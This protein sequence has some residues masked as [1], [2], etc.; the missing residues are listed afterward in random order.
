MPPSQTGRLASLVDR[1]RLTWRFG[2][3]VGRI[4]V[5]SFGGELG[6]RRVNHCE[7]RP[8]TDPLSASGDL[9]CRQASQRRD[10]SVSER[11][12]LGRH[13]QLIADLQPGSSEPLL[14]HDQAAELRDEPRRDTGCL[15]E[16][17]RVEPATKEEEEPPQAGVRCSKEA[18][19]RSRQMRGIRK[20]FR[21]QARTS[22]QF[23]R[24]VRI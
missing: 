13:E 14:Q 20:R 12:A 5:R 3:R 4:E 24:G 15:L 8:Q 18:R 10:I 23:R 22:T 11:R 9:R 1:R 17:V 2:C 6:R 19:Q 7:P 16:D 21:R